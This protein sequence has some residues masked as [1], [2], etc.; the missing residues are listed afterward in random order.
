MLTRR[1]LLTS[2]GIAAISAPTLGCSFDGAAATANP[3]AT[4]HQTAGPFYPDEFPAD[5][6]ADLLQL[7]GSANAAQGEAVNVT[8]TVKSSDGEPISGATVD[9]WQCDANGVYHHPADRTEGRDAAFQ[10]FGR[11]E[12]DANGHFAFRTIRPVPYPGR[13]PHIHV[14]VWRHGTSVLTTQF[15]DGRQTDANAADGLYRRMSEAERELV[16]V[17]FVE[18]RAEPGALMARLDVWLA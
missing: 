13:T 8:G 1:E 7:V 10:G 14:R 6:D 16:T 17:D 11:T 9:L 5:H 15:Y 3:R 2:A 18:D 4:P 12:T